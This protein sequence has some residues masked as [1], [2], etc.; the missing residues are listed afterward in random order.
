M[1]LFAKWLRADGLT[2]RALTV[3]CGVLFGRFDAL[4]ALTGAAS[5]LNTDFVWFLVVEDSL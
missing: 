3:R 5:C 4:I 2:L 1:L